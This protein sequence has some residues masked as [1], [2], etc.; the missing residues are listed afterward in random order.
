MALKASKKHVKEIL[1]LFKNGTSQLVLTGDARTGKTWMARAV[2]E[3]AVREGDCFG[4]LWISMDQNYDE[5]SLYETIAWQLS[6]LT[7]EEEWED[8]ADNKRKEESVEDLKQKIRVKL[9]KEAEETKFLLLVLDCEGEKTT[10][11]DIRNKLGLD[12][13][14]KMKS[15]ESFKL[16][17]LIT[18]KKSE[19]GTITRES[20]KME[21]LSGEEALSL[22]KDSVKSKV[23]A[24]QGFGELSMAIKERSYVLPDEIMM[25]AGALNYFTKDK[26]QQVSQLAPALELALD[27]AAN[28]NIP[29]L[30][31]AYDMLPNDCIINCFWHCWHFLGKHRGVNYNELI[32]HWILEGYLDHADC[33]EKAYEMSHDMLMELIDRGML[34]MQ[35]DNMIAAEAA[36]LDI[37]DRYCRGFSRLAN[38]GLASVLEDE[39]RKVFE[40]ITP[41]DSMIKTLGGDTKEERI[42]SLLIDGSHLC[43]EIP[44]TFFRAKQD[45]KV[46][47]IFNPRL[48]TFPFSDSKMEKLIVLVLR[49]SYLLEDCSHIAKLKALTVLEISGA[50]YMEEIPDGLFYEVPQLRSLNLS[51]LGVRLLPSSLSKLTELRRLILRQCYCLEELPKLDKLEKLEVLDLSGCTSLRKIQDKCFKSQLKLQVLD[52]SETRIEKMPIVK[53]LKDLVRL[54]LKGCKCLTLLRN[55]KGLSCL[56]IVDL[57]G[58]VKIEEINDDC[59]EKTDNLRVLDLSYTKIQCLPS[60]I[61]NLCDLRL[62]GCSILENLPSTTALV[63]LESLD[64]SEATSLTKIQDESFEHLQHLSFINLSNTKIATLPSL[65]NLQKLQKLLLKDCSL[66]QSLPAMKGLA[67]LEVFDLSGCKAISEIRDEAFEDMSMLQELNL[68]ET[69]I[70]HLPSSF[71]NPR[72]LHSLVA[73]DCIN[74]ES[75]PDLKS[76][77]ELVVL[78]LSGTNSLNEIKAE[79]LNHMTH[80]RTLKLSK[81]AFEE[82]SSLSSLINLHKLSL[83]DC[84]VMQ[85]QT[86]GAVKSLPSLENLRNLHELSLRGFSSLMELP[87]LKSLI[88]LEVLDLSK[89]GV[90]KLPHEISELSG[91]N[92]LYLPDLKLIQGVRWKDRKRLDLHWD[93]CSTESSDI[94]SDSDAKKPFLVVHSTEFFRKLKEDPKLLDTASKLFK[95]LIFSIHSSKL[96]CLDKDDSQQMGELIYSDVYFKIKNFP[97]D[98]KDG[99]CME[100]QGFKSFPANVGNDIQEVLMDTEYV[101]LIENENL[102]FLSDLKP[103]NLKKIKGCWIERCTKMKSIFDETSTEIGE[104]LESL[105]ISTLPNLMGLYHGEMQHVSFR[106]LKHLCLVCC[107]SIETVFDSSQLP[108]TLEVLQ[109][110]FCDR[111]KALVAHE[112]TENSDSQY[113]SLSNLK[114]LDIYSCPMIETVLPFVPENLVS[115]HIKCCDKLQRLFVQQEL[116][117]SE[118]S[119][120]KTLHLFALPE[121][122]SVGFKLQKLENVKGCPKLKV[123]EVIVEPGIASSE[124]TRNG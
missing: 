115:V 88:H 74:L 91:L 52:F 5:K 110:K 69:R 45:L 9:D 96:K 108:E 106:K 87:S 64:L 83:N 72:N 71:C 61:G 56:K 90:Q 114:E 89:T 76:L 124:I 119:T 42:S 35:E 111:L 37:D 79:S 59:F 6:L 104:R 123:E 22:L 94:L 10:E 66:L 117:N 101:S 63:N 31:Y 58:A 14:L 43:R 65:C 122:T 116:A 107:P 38:L 92:F 93:Q 98:G 11:D 102:R 47:A 46:L 62:K 15:G 3:S 25:L 95:R 81:L 103:E 55:L 67:G 4:T 23:W 85:S 44:E 49:G 1:E 39:E 57:S 17:V 20:K 40:G 29:L 53:F 109:I 51:V 36:I 21:P 60:S 75:L 84:S 24:F 33:M 30:Q 113:M 112:E 118:L 18:K 77:S 48:K 97:P 28:A 99:Q 2:S 13:V 12:D 105:W 54:S 19:E 70:K 16:K 73:K 50:T 8:G 32:T 120:L 86:G 26:S 121:L 34:R 27:A 82:L 41:G 78:D 68:S 80:L 7:S 100:I